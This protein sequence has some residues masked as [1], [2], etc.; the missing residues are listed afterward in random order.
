MESLKLCG[1]ANEHET[2]EQIDEHTE[3]IYGFGQQGTL[4]GGLVKVRF[5][6]S[7]G[8]V[9]RNAFVRS[10]STLKEVVM[11]EG[12]LK[13]DSEAFYICDA[14]EEVIM[15]STV[16]FIESSAFSKC[17]QLGKVELNEGLLQL[18]EW[19]FE[20]CI[21]LESITIP[22]T[23]KC[24]DGYTFSGC[25]SLKEVS[26]GTGIE[27]ISHSAFAG[28]RKLRQVV[29]N[30]GLKKI[31]KDSFLNCINLNEVVMNE[32]NI[33]SINCHAF[34]G[35]RL[36]KIILQSLSTRVSTI[37]QAGN[38]QVEGKLNSILGFY[39][40]CKDEQIYL[41][42]QAYASGGGGPSDLN[43]WKQIK[44][45]YLGRIDD[46][47]SFY[48]RKEATIIFELAWWKNKIDNP[49]E[50]SP[51]S[52]EEC[53]TDIPG[54]AKDMIWQYLSHASNRGA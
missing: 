22:S 30:D 39:L 48:E 49:E 45:N 27:S 24:I 11:N 53:R 42:V 38:T 5:D 44:D 8:E 34:R 31:G 46:M 2:E 43:L 20:G 36:Q 4:P 26:F 50:D 18:G 14:L 13:L 3:Y 33:Q 29:F 54:P 47:L 16:Q 32:T 10:R 28:C 9:R 12:L 1:I 7:V 52:R 17:Y 41:K 25:V 37:V 21:N 15:P 51:V 19:S 6:P 23:L 40:G 35:C